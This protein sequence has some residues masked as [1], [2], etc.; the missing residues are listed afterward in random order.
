MESKSSYLKLIGLGVLALGMVGRA[1]AEPELGGGA[2]A[3]DAIAEVMYCYARATD[4]IGDTKTNPDPRAAG[5]AIYR[6]CFTDDAVFRAW[7][8][9]Q[10]FNSQTFPNPGTMPPTATVN[11]VSAWA[12]FVSGVFRGNGYNFTQHMITNIKVNTQGRQ[13]TLTA[14]LN[15]SHVIAGDPKNVGGPSKCVAVANGTYSLHLEKRNGRWKATSLDLTLITFN[16]VFETG[17]GCAPPGP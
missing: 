17:T 9:Q 5:L 2:K 11:G 10:P 7:F 4:A 12:D 14:Y 15:A 3:E 1:L 8:P 13:G 6:T 16:P